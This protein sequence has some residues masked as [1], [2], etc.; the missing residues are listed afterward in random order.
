[1][2]GGLALLFVVVPLVELIVL[3]RLGQTFGFLN[4]VAVMVLMSVAGAWLAKREGVGVV[5]RLQAD[6]R[7]GRAP[8]AALVDGF[9]VL[10]A[11]ALLLTPGFVSDAVALLLLVPPVRA[12]LRRG[13]V[14]FFARRAAVRVARW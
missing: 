7:A 9:L 3:L 8:A 10:F 2:V 11:A 1:M 5:R 14:G 12:G 13:L 4:T 6:V